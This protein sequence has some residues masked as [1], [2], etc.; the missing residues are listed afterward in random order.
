V[1]SFAEL[2]RGYLRELY[3]DS[4][5]MASNL[6]I[7]GYDD[8][9]DDLS[10]AAFERRLARKA[11][12]LQR[13]AAVPDQGLSFDECI[14]RD[15]ILSDLR[16]AEIMAGWQMWRRQPAAYLNPGLAGIFSLFLHRLKPEPE[17]ARA[18]AARLRALPGN[19]ADGKK[20]LR[21]E[22]APRVYI[23]RAV[24]QARAGARYARELVPAEVSDP[25]LRSELAEAGAVAAAA[26]DDFADFLGVLAG[27]AHG[28]W[29][30]GGERYSRL[31]REKELLGY[32]ATALRERGRAEYD[33]LA[34]QLRRCARDLEGT[35]DWVHVLERL[36]QDHPPTPEAM[37]Q[38]YAEWTEKARQFLKDRRLVSFPEGE[39]CAVEPSPPFQRP[40]IAVA[41]YQNPP[42][43]SSSLKGH[44]FVPFPPD[45]APAEEVQKRLESNSYAG[46]PTTAVHEAY[47]GHHWHLIVAKRNPSAARQVFRT[48]YFIEGWG[49]YAERMMREQGFFTDPRH[50]MFQYEATL[51]RA[52]RIIVDTSL[53]LGEMSF[54]EAVRFMME[55]ANLPE[56]TAKAEV[57]RYCSWPTQ[58]SSYLT[59]SIEIVR[60]RERYM[61]EKGVSGTDGLRAFHD[62]IA[63]S[64]CLP[65][66]LAERAALA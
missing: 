25:A 53:H 21:P 10:E 29:A 62:T 35:D 30:V 12:W 49:L 32:G 64:G 48:S 59:G 37:R 55:R 51:F 39:A 36:N 28:E 24:G 45:G 38:S 42:T 23:E 60:I 34:E 66:A 61:S 27:H 19:L 13:F 15:L 20:N 47:P 11:A 33:L 22:L 43:F 57:G 16:G 9:L 8:R 56:P 5:V 6:G 7:E 50:Q 31:L 26:F 2:V 52:A 54:D 4:P 63:R 58:A 40:V 3:D 17:L 14:D 44:F 65:T 18:A 1:S 46:I 41:S